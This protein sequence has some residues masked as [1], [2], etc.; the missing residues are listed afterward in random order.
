[1]N[2]IP[3][4]TRSK[5]SKAINKTKSAKRSKKR[6]EWI[7]ISLLHLI[8]IVLIVLVIWGF[9]LTTPS[10]IHSLN[11]NNFNSSSDINLLNQT[12]IQFSLIC[13]YCLIFW[14]YAV[15][16]V[17]NFIPCSWPK[18]VSMVQAQSQQNGESS[19][20]INWICYHDKCVFCWCS[21]MVKLNSNS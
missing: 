20:P 2:S 9:W 18:L 11:C 14:A 1:M 13:F 17:M 19:T 3:N 5:Q 15:N 6:D 12:W 21:R 16:S 4:D 8:H 10:V 7:Q